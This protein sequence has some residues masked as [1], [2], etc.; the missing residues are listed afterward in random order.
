MTWNDLAKHI[1]RMSL[2][3]RKDNVTVKVQSLDGFFTDVTLE[4]TG[5]EPDVLDPNAFY[6]DVDNG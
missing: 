6:L 3:Q 4:I 5:E 1:E 2:D